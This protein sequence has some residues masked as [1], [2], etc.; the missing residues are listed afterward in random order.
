MKS[1]SSFSSSLEKSPSLVTVFNSGCYSF[2]LI[3][4]SLFSKG[5]FAALFVT[6]T[7]A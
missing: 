6:I 4:P 3:V 7:P 5:V 2:K 1:S